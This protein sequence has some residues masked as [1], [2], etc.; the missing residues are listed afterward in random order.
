MRIIMSKWS[1]EKSWEW[2]KQ[3][4]WLRGFNY[5]PRTAVNWTEMWQQDTVR[6]GLYDSRAAMGC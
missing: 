1:E 6:S 5:L 4:G 3:Q 2:H